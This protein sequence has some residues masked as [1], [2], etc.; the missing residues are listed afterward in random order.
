MGSGGKVKKQSRVNTEFSIGKVKKTMNRLVRHKQK[1]GFK[2]CVT[3]A[4]SLDIINKPFFEELVRLTNDK[5]QASAVTLAKALQKEDAVYYGLFPKA[6]AGV[7]FSSA[8][9][10]LPAAE[11]SAE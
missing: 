11:G 2:T 10:E 3:I 5:N 8:I 9:E 7:F 1:V 6:I 4:R